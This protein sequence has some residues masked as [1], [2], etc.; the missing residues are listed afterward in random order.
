MRSTKGKGS[1]LLY[2]VMFFF[3][4]TPAC[5]AQ[6]DPGVRQGPPGAGAPL[7]DLTAIESAMFNE[8]LQRAIQLEAVCDDCNDVT[9]GS[10]VDPTKANFIVQTNSSGLGTRFNADQCTA[11]H[12][13]PALGG[14]GG[15]LVPNPQDPPAKH[16]A[17]ENPE[18]H[19][20]AHRKD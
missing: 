2:A 1:R 6:K 7:R 13:Q 14:S 10:F 9:L 11:C 15:F 8:G 12:S 16:R 3:T 19:L 5:F 4:L 17:P 18:S 20:I